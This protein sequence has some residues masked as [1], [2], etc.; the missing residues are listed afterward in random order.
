MLQRRPN[1]PAALNS[2]GI[3]QLKQREFNKAIVNFE[4]AVEL[5]PASAQVAQNLGRFNFLARAGVIRTG[6]QKVP[7][8]VAARYAAL[9][10]KIIAEGKTPEANLSKGWLHMQPVLPDAEQEPTPQQKASGARAEG[11]V[12]C[13]SGTGFAVGRGHV[14]TNRHVVYPQESGYGVADQV[15]VIDPRDPAK[16]RELVGKVVALADDSDLA[17]LHFPGLDAAALPLRKDTAD[18]GSE[19]MILGYPQATILGTSL[20][21]TTGIVSGLPDPTRREE[22]ADCYLF[23]ATSDSGNSGGPVVDKTGRVIGV[24]TF[25]LLINADLSGGVP[26]TRAAEFIEQHV[27]GL[28]VNQNPPA[29][30][31]G[32][33]STVVKSAQPSVFQLSVCYQSGV[34]ALTAAAGKSKIRRDAM[35]DYTCAVCSGAASVDCSNPKCRNGEVR[36]QYTEMVPILTGAP[37]RRV[38][39]PVKKYRNDP[40]EFC[41]GKGKVDCQDCV[42]GIDTSLVK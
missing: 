17:L 14:L 4:R 10:A 36:V 30:P 22:S 6:R 42:L 13:F 34:P 5:A 24:L 31:H 12:R 35:E 37:V 33:W 19:V 23:D 16:K 18:L 21:A 26:A 40:C 15:R 41:N 2:L 20:K 38:M 9:Y 8:G 39:T 11:F 29:D 27:P 32:D 7:D 3:A 1:D 28:L 25:I